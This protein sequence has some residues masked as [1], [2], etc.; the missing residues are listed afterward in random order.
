MRVADLIPIDDPRVRLAAVALAASALTATTIFTAQYFD[1]RNKIKKIKEEI[2]QS[3]HTTLSHMDDG[4]GQ[5]NGHGRAVKPFV[6]DEGLIREQLARNYA[7]LGEEGVAKVRKS[8]VVV[9]GLGGVGSHAAHML[10]R[11][12]VEHL[13]LIDFDQV[14]LSSLNRHAL[15]TQNDVG[16]PKATC[17]KKHFNEIFPNAKIEICVDM[18]TPT[19]APLLL[20]GNPDFVLDCI[21]NLSTKVDLIKYC[22]QNNIR[23]MSSM[24]AGAKADPSRIQIA[25]ISDTFEDPLARATRRRLRLEG[26]ESGVTVV[27]STEKPGPVTLL[28]LEEDKVANADEYAALPNFR[29]RILPVLG[30]LPALFGNSMASHVVTELAGFKTEP[31]PIKLRPKTYERLHRD[32][33]NREK[34]V[35]KASPNIPL[36][37]GDVGYIFEEIWRGRSALSNGFDKLQLTRWDVTKPAAFNNVIC[38]TRVEADKHDKI[39]PGQL[40][41]TYGREFVDFVEGRFEEERRVRK[42]R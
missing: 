6:A 5:G 34:D 25:D 8:F 27:Y 10:L 1:K 4:L 35:F 7:F 31:L 17:L 18:Y 23:V 41:S 3:L 20:A 12:G 32:L 24:G 9:V 26:V 21:D 36:N 39:L 38:F 30:T 13:R 2:S 29:V 37:V 15:A 42:W 11:S 28:P 22:K 16:T 40:E 14:T 33:V 19:S